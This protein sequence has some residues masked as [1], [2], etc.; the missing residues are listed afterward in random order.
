MSRKK[1]RYVVVKSNSETVAVFMDKSV[2][3]AYI[4]D[5]NESN[6]IC[7]ELIEIDVE[8]IHEYM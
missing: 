8:D 5:S 6:G 2:A 7:L 1:M 3:E 4:S